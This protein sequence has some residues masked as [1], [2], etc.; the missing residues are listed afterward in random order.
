MPRLESPEE[1]DRASA[2]EQSALSSQSFNSSLSDIKAIF[3]SSSKGAV[4]ALEEQFG[5]LL[6]VDDSASVPAVR[7]DSE[8]PNKIFLKG[9]PQDRII[10]DVND[11]PVRR[12]DSQNGVTEL[13]ENGQTRRV[14]EV[15]QDGLRSREV[16]VP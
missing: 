11:P 14:A 8:A 6:L 15:D 10:E 13:D 7:N 9:D 3:G 1:L 5:G 2:T 16:K 4:D 12:I